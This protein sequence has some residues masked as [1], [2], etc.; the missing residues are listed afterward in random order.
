MEFLTMMSFY[1]DQ[2][3]I[4]P[5][6]TYHDMYV[7][8]PI[9]SDETLTSASIDAFHKYKFQKMPIFFDADTLA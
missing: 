8:I 9:S 6:S 2:G 1:K 5:V 3:L 4:I 7:A